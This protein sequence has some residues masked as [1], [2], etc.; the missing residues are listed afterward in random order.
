MQTHVIVGA[1]LIP[2]VKYRSDS[3]ALSVHSHHLLCC[4]AAVVEP[5]PVLLLSAGSCETATTATPSVAHLV[6]RTLTCCSLVHFKGCDKEQLLCQSHTRCGPTSPTCLLFL[7]RRPSSPSCTCHVFP[8]ASELGIFLPR[9]LAAFSAANRIISRQC[10][11][12]GLKTHP[13]ALSL[14]LSLRQHK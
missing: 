9:C 11:G 4:I 6:G 8:S 12:F 2:S 13:S 10:F 7:S 5:F 14:S 3:A 1:L